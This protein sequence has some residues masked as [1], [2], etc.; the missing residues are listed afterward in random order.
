MTENIFDQASTKE[1]SPQT[2]LATLKEVLPLL[3]CD[4]ELIFTGSLSAQISQLEKD[5]K[6]TL[7][8]E[9]LA[10]VNDMDI[11]TTKWGIDDIKQKTKTISERT[12]FHIEISPIFQNCAYHSSGVRNLSVQSADLTIEGDEPN[13]IYKISYTSPEFL[14]LTLADQEVTDKTPPEKYKRKVLSIQNNPKF[15][16]ERFSDLVHNELAARYALNEDTFNVWKRSI[17]EQAND[18]DLAKEFE[19]VSSLLDQSRFFNTVRS[20]QDLKEL[21]Y[22]EVRKIPQLEHFL[23]EM[24]EEL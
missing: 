15:S 7:K 20:P 6:V 2:K 23:R 19:S 10:G 16:K 1:V 5:G 17:L 12:G 13:K 11:A 9:D 24:E 8:P 21:P 22:S 18:V 3:N 4:Q 14:L